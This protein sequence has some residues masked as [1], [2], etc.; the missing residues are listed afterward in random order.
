LVAAIHDPFGYDLGG[1]HPFSLVLVVV[2]DPL[3]CDRHVDHHFPSPFSS[4]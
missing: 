3:N 1:P 4:L 2:S